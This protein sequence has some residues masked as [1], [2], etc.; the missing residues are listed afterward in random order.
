MDLV[1]L[2]RTTFAQRVS[3]NPR[4]SHRAFAQSLALH[5][6]TLLRLLAGSRSLSS[7]RIAAIARRLGLPD[8]DARALVEGEHARKVLAATR[9]NGFRPDSRHLASRTGL[10]LDDVNRALHWLIY[11]RRLRLT[12]RGTW[13]AEDA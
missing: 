6:S 9:A 4:Y 3:V 7:G 12:G 10:P 13:H 2:L 11:H 5:H 1:A 8:A